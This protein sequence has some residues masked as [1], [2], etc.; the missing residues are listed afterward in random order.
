MEEALDSLAGEEEGGE[1][2]GGG[3]PIY[4]EGEEGEEEEEEEEG[5]HS[6]RWNPL[7]EMFLLWLWQEDLWQE[8][9]EAKLVACCACV[10]VWAEEKG[11][12]APL[13]GE[14]LVALA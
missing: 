12:W 8:E 1:E 9:R 11:H 2:D 10:E 3:G 14:E 4:W 7:L 6:S 13:L 5:V